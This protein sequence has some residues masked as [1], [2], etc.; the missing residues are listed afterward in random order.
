MTY[1]FNAYL[2]TRSKNTFQDD[3]VL[4]TCL[5]KL[6]PPHSRGMTAKK[7]L[8]EIGK[9]AAETMP[10]LSQTAA[11]KE[12]EPKL[13]P[14]NAFNE[15]IHDIEIHASTQKLMQD[16][17][18]FKLGF[19]NGNIFEHY[20]KLY[21]IAQNGE[22][23]VCC[24]LACSDGLERI[25]RKYKGQNKI[26]KK[27]HWDLTHPTPNQFYHGAQFVTEIQ[28]GSDVA[29]NEVKAV[30]KGKDWSISGHKW[31]C[32][33]IT[34]NYFLVTAKCEE[35][36]KL[37]KNVS[38]FLVPNIPTTYEVHRLKDK[39]GTRELPTAEVTFQDAKATLVGPRGKG[40]S[41]VVSEVLVTSTLHC[42]MSGCA[43]LK[44]AHREVEAYTHFR[45][46]FGR[47]IHHY[48]LVQ[49]TLDELK[50]EHEKITYG[51][52]HL[53][54]R[55]EAS[56][57]NPKTK[58][59]IDTRILISLMKPYATWKATYFLHEAMMLLAGNGIE[60]QFSQ[61]P[62][63]FRD[64][65]IYETWEGAHFVL[66]TQ[67]YKD[68]KVFGIDQDTAGFVKRILGKHHPLE[69]TLKGILQEKDS[70]RALLQFKNWATQ[71]ISLF[72]LMDQSIGYDF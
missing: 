31:F 6:A 29:A 18:N 59:A 64:A 71:F 16:L 56:Q 14:Y 13:H 49:K 51:F 53:L 54:K 69:N 30:L 4:Q 47:P 32:S 10:S 1:T 62:R 40:V 28:G 70:Q 44:K 55:W 2:K 48:S 25:L 52:F 5:K 15:R 36:G 7:E 61:L 20:A 9:Y 66:L 17:Y 23:G 41:L 72:L 3:A 63:L 57:K 42:I 46:A 37:D 24:S 67:A 43:L 34:A 38:L 60:E 11:R 45:H 39:L 65:V 35:N 58:D 50:I 68:M 8:L 19:S 26:L 22:A 12:N 27:A 33:N 21:L